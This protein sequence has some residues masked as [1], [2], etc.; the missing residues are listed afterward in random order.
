MEI[1]SPRTA[2]G[3]GYSG[4]SNRARTRRQRVENRDGRSRGVGTANPPG[5]L[6]SISAGTVST[7]HN[8]RRMFLGPL[9]CAYALRPVW[10]CQNRL[11]KSGVH[12]FQNSYH[13]LM[14]ET[15]VFQTCWLSNNAS[16][17]GIE[18]AFSICPTHHQLRRSALRL[19]HWRS[20]EPPGTP[21]L[22]PRPDFRRKL[23]CKIASRFAVK[24]RLMKS[25][26]Q[27]L[28]HDSLVV[29]TLPS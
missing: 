3:L 1:P 20:D 13:N 11:T 23:F 5:L 22:P 29:A 8:G 19:G 15:G 10:L 26:Q 2:D 24:A 7:S 6:L 28:L 4:N 21:A 12:R 27:F 9:Q 14:P 18:C 25:F 17:T 16:L